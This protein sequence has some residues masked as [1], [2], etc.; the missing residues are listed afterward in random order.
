LFLSFVITLKCDFIFEKF[1][2]LEILG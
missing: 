2:N 1:K